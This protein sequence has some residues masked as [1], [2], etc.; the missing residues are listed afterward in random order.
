LIFVISGALLHITNPQT[1]EVACYFS[2]EIISIY[3]PS[4]GGQRAV[5]GAFMPSAAQT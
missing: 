5:Q 3:M 2:S 1:F 4:A